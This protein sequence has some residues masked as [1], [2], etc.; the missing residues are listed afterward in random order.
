MDKFSSRYARELKTINAM[1]GIFCH[2]IHKPAKGP[3]P[4]CAALM[5]YVLARLERCPFGEEKPACA[6]CQVHCYQPEKRQ[7]IREVM[8]Y[9]GP[10][11]M[12][13]HPLL[14]LRHLINKFVNR[15]NVRPPKHERKVP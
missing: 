7:K 8:R 15:D 13:R 12:K 14:A 10:R 9:A 6:Q 11:M 2:D 1:V 4:D 3:C 5:A